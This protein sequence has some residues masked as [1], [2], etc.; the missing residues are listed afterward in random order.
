ME[1]QIEAILIL[2]MPRWNELPDIDL[3][4]DQVVNYIERY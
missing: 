2:H 4:L 1:E 3:Y